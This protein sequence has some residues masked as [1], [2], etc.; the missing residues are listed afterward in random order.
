[1][2]K[3]VYRPP[4]VAGMFYPGNP[5]TL[6]RDLDTLFQK[7]LPN[8]SKSKVFG[9]IAP[10]AGYVYSGFTAAM[11]YNQIKGRNYNTVIIISPSHREYFPGISIYNG[12]GYETPLGTIE[13]DQEL[14]QK[15]IECGEPIFE[16]IQGHRS[17]HALEVQLP[18][19]QKILKNFKIVPIVMGD[20]NSKICTHLGESI[21][22]VLEGR[23]DVLIVA[24]SDLSH[25]YTS[26]E[27]K[28]L[29]KVIM[30]DVN[31]FDWEKLLIDLSAKR[32]E[33][34]GGGPIAAMLIAAKKLGADKSEVVHYCDSGDVTG[35]KSE[36]V[37]YLSALIWKSN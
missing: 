37:G 30:D 33:A 24:S 4:A 7:A 8:E 28:K 21:G 35:D 19:L 12:K 25:F 2:N 32:T 13:V 14:K 9:L 17:E 26:N 6:S 20:Q 1:M 36:V 31:S 10:H 34:C 27:A 22:K 11:A 18:F 3:D 16:S 5:E 15:L 29:D 23:E